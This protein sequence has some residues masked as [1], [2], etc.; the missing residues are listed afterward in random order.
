MTSHHPLAHPARQDSTTT[1]LRLQLARDAAQLGYWDYEISS[2]ELVW[3][4]LCAR[5]F[6]ISL[7]DFEGSLASFERR[8]HPEDL[9]RVTEVL[10]ATGPGESMETTFRAV[11]PDGSVRHLLSRGQAVADDRGEVERIVG[12]VLDVSR[13]HLGAERLGGLARLAL[14]LAGVED[15]TSLTRAVTEHAAAVLGADGTAVCVRDDERGSLRIVVSDEQ[16]GQWPELD[17]LPL[18][19]PLPLSVAA[20]TG[21]AVLLGDRD[22]AIASAPSMQEVLDATGRAAWAVLPLR[23]ADRLLGSLVVSWTD[24][25]VL[26]QDE[27]EL[28]AALAAQTAQAL[29]RVQALQAERRQAAEVRR[30]SET[31]QRSLLSAPPQP[32]DLRVAVRYVPA[33]QEAAVGGDW[34]DGFVVPDGALTLVIGDCVGHDR[35]AAA[36]MATMRNL[37]RATAYAIEEPPA[38]VLTAL[39]RALR[40]LDV[41]VLATALLARVEQTERQRRAGLRRVT[42]SSAGHLPP[43]LR[44]PDGSA[45]VLESEPDVLLG[46]AVEGPRTDRSVDVPIGSTLLLYTDGLVERRGEDLDV[47]IERLQRLVAELGALSLEDLCDALLAD[48]LGD[49]AE[50]DVALLAVRFHSTDE[51]SMLVGPMAL[52]AERSLS[53]P[54]HPAS[55]RAARRFVRSFLDELGWEARIEAAELAVSEIVTNA[56]LHAHTDLTLTASAQAGRLRVEVRDRN[57]SLP[58]LRSYDEQA[59]TGRGMALVAAVS[60]DHGVQSLGSAGKVVWFALG[61]GSDQGT[62]EEDLLASWEDL[63][64]AAPLYATAA[65][66]QG[67]PATLWAAARQH[68]DALIRELTL[69]RAS[70]AIS[71]EDIVVADAARRSISD[72]VERA[73]GLAQ[74]VG[75]PGTQL[76]DGHPSPLPVSPH[77]VD[78]HVPALLDARAYAVLQ[79]VLDGAESLAARDELLVRPG[80]PEIIAVRDWACEQVIAQLAGTAPSP[81]PG[82]DAERFTVLQ[83]VDAVRALDWEPSGV[84]GSDRAAVAADDANRIVAVSRPLCEALGYT[85]EE[86]LGRRVVVLVPHRFREA[87]VAGF[88]RHLT[89]GES[90][91]LGVD[92]E[93]PVLRA[94]GTELTCRF[95]IEASGTPSGRTVYTAWITPLT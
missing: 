17:Q 48:L 50:D 90:H 47:G 37:L 60:T 33:S 49:D 83:H 58:S 94:D 75:V 12:V 67:V 57:P 40:G 81:W 38:A 63:E 61:D 30:L 84:S 19:G 42:W 46:L 92:L 7:E 56:V 69:L 72:A 4:D 25:Q 11:Q 44:L 59:T 86:L 78:A 2:R 39:E 6:G 82:T 31:W 1:S 23:S 55:A 95:L 8:C 85:E 52:S 34:Y 66:L 15:E 89:T 87:H 74:Q 80:L 43:I 13:L 29:D 27:R 76:P 9:P 18:D 77:T 36:A 73:V 20:R 5:M 71:G 68:H 62:T 28:L 65:V 41:E 14:A 53:L 51:A 91:V 16:D 79:D 3:D 21:E 10:A 93:L 35:H 54:A 26:G 32:D 24:P 70:R 64:G 22:A 88:T 45:V